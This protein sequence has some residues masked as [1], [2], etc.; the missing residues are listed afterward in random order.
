MF[1]LALKDELDNEEEEGKSRESD[2]SEV[3]CPMV[4]GIGIYLKR[5]LMKKNVFFSE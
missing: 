1:D 5:R 4:I 3:N 2:F